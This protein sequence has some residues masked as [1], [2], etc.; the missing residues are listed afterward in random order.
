MRHISHEQMPCEM[1]WKQCVP[2][3]LLRASYFTFVELFYPALEG[4]GSLM[5]GRTSAANSL[6]AQVWFLNAGHQIHTR[7]NTECTA[8]M[9]SVS[10]EGQRRVGCYFFTELSVSIRQTRFLLYLDRAKGG[11]HS[12][13]VEALVWFPKEPSSEQL[14][15]E[16]FFS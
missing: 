1:M 13:G 7:G 10:S 9:S 5:M 2:V 8:E 3:S 12:D 14:L 11:F 15:K 16:P 6:N 4:T